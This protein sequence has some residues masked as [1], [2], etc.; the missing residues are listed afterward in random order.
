MASSPS[1]P[2]IIGETGLR[3]RLARAKVRDGSCAMRLTGPLLRHLL[4]PE[5]ML[6]GIVIR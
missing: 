3:T 5:E 2:C 4:A 1:S 6:S